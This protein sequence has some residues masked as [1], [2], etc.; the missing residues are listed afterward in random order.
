MVPDGLHKKT[1]TCG[2]A[3]GQTD[4][5]RDGSKTGKVSDRAPAVP[6]IPTSDADISETSE[7]SREQV[8]KSAFN[9]LPETTSDYY[10]DVAG[11]SG[12]DSQNHL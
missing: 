1:E 3:Q 8:S 9:S 4:R 10:S 11:A 12:T 7:S 5:Q 6:T 2:H